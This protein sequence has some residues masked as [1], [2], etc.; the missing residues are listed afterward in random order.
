MSVRH[1][2]NRFTL[3]LPFFS[4]C[5]PWSTYTDQRKF[6]VLA[7]KTHGQNCVSMAP[8]R[9][10][11][12]MAWNSPQL[13]SPSWLD[14]AKTW[15]NMRCLLCLIKANLVSSHTHITR[16]HHKVPLVLHHGKMQRNWISIYKCFELWGM[17]VQG[18]TLT[19]WSMVIA[20]NFDTNDKK[21]KANTFKKTIAL[22]LESLMGLKLTRQSSH[23][24][25][26]WTEEVGHDV[27]PWLLTSLSQL[28]FYMM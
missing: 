1:C 2:L 8:Q 11:S 9:I 22:Y 27:I 23:L 16:L 18:H 10:P 12:W 14:R 15:K 20:K 28:L 19:S 25:D 26:L 13:W 6:L 7:V 4:T 24:P 21:N 3:T 17:L 5:Q